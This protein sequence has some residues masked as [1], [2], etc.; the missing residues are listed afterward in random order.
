MN[1][2][3]R[4]TLSQVLELL[5]LGKVTSEELTRACLEEIE[6]TKDLNALISVD[7]KYA[8]SEAKKADERRRVG[9]KLPLL[10][11]PVIIKDNIS[12]EHFKTTCASKFLANYVAPYEATVVKRLREAGAVIIAKANMDEFACGA[13]GE[14]SA[15]GATLNPVDKTRVAGGSSSG[16]ASSVSAY[17]A[18]ASLGTDTGGSIRQPAGFCGVVGMKPTYGRVS[19]YGVVA[20]ASSLD[21]VGP[22]TRT[23][24]DNAKIL[25][26]ISGKDEM[27]STSANVPVENYSFA[28]NESIKG[29]RIGVAKEYFALEAS[30]EVRREIERTIE[31]YREN[32]AEIVNIS[33]PNVSKALAVY[34][35]LSSA[36]LSSNLSRFDGIKYG[37]R[38]E[39]YDGV[40]DLY[41]K[42]RSKGFGAEV[43]RRIMTGNYSLSAGY[44]DAYYKKASDVREILKKEFADAF[45]KCDAIISPVSPTTAF[46]VGEK[47]TPL[48]NYLADIYTVPVNIVGVPAISFPVGKDSEG[49]PIACQL[50]ANYFDEK[51]L[52]SLAGCYERIHGGVR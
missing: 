18:Y 8:L 2:L 15:F 30:P 35:I 31:F 13:S 27:D 32:G 12:T 52:Y 50:I 11:V 34:Y 36:E 22:I 37:E 28:V 10:G 4:Y 1:K 23:V 43:K 38:G 14:N 21:Q 9:E 39:N 6:S 29:K 24:E 47:K 41:Y 5:E 44:F 16:S 19:R 48:E 45:S 49:L 17:N 25:E 40:V 3:C 51:T 20:F 33:L 46:K 42:S 26:I 7:H